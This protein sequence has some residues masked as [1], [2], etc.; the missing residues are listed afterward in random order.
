M[1]RTNCDVGVKEAAQGEVPHSESYESFPCCLENE[2]VSAVLL[3]PDSVIESCKPGEL[4][5]VNQS[6]D[7]ERMK[8]GVAE[9]LNAGFV[10]IVGTT[11]GY[12]HVFSS[13]SM[14]KRA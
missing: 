5:R 12:V 13:F 8:E 14:P 4:N 3:A 2:S 1:W 7:N 6:V 9:D 10:F 11:D